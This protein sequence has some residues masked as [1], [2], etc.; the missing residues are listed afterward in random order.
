MVDNKY[1][2]DLGFW[3]PGHKDGSLDPFVCMR[4]ADMFYLIT[5]PGN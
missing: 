4:I 3:I 1:D 5:S 2:L